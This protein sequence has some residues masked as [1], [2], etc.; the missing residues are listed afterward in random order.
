[1][2]GGRGGGEILQSWRTEGRRGRGEGKVQVR[3]GGERGGDGR[4]RSCLRSKRRKEVAGLGFS[5]VAVMKG[6]KIK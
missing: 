2:C 3:A 1:M 6:S 4:D 5:V